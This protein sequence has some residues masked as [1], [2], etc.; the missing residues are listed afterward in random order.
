M[1]SPA[2][3][4][5]LNRPLNCATIPPAVAASPPEGRSRE[6]RP[7][8]F[9][10]KEWMEV[11]KR[12]SVK[13]ATYDRLVTS[14]NLMLNYGISNVSVA[15][16]SATDVRK[17]LNKLVD[18]GYALSTI[19]KQFRLLTSYFSWAANEGIIT[20]NPT[21][22][23][24][25]PKEEAVRKHVKEIEA[26]TM[27]QQRALL[28]VLQSHAYPAYA[29][30]ELMLETGMRPG[31]VIALAW[32]DVDWDRRAINIS[33]T[34]VRYRN[35]SDV[36]IQGSPKSKASKRPIP[37]SKRALAIMQELFNQTDALEGLIFARED[38]KPMSY[39]MVRWHIKMACKQANVPYYGLHVFRHTFAT[40]CYNRGCNVKLLSKMLGHSS[41]AITYNVYIHLYGD[42][43]EEMRNIVG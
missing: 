13:A 22:N 29:I 2:A 31:E 17:Y 41:A 33:K 20:L 23:V 15:S 30:A 12:N 11:C 19:K 16:L 18:A 5:A 24:K 9:A 35:S 3:F 27:P 10:I 36:F 28:N 37:L 1:S 6:M 14:Y 32:E 21:A 34:A 25:P 4:S 26:Y 39:D 7:L 8:G 43:L 38:G 40:N 42:L